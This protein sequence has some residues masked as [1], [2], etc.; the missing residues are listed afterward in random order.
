MDSIMISKANADTIMKKNDSQPQTMAPT[1]TPPRTS[2]Y[3]NVAA[4]DDAAAP[5]MCCQ[6]AESKDVIAEA[7]RQPSATWDTGRAGKGFT[8]YVLASD[9]PGSSCQPGK[10]ARRTMATRPKTTDTKLQSSC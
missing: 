7:A 9:V 1:P 2:P 5:A 6:K 4:N 3:V 8:S 10:V